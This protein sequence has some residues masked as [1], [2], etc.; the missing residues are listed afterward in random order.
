MRNR[1][2]RE[3]AER[4]DDGDGGLVDEGDAIPEEISVRCH[5]QQCPLANSESWRCFN[6]QKVALLLAKNIGI[7]AL[8]GVVRRPAL[9]ACRHILT[10]VLTDWTRLRRA[11]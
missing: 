6:T 7:S 8:H 3:T 9:A 1:D 5:D 10:F 4:F 11:H 2:P